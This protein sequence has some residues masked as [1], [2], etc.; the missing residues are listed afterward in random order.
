MNRSHLGACAV[1]ALL[2]A[3]PASAMG[4]GPQI[5]YVPNSL[6]ELKINLGPWT[7]HEEGEYF[8]HD[9][10]GIVPTGSRPPYTGSGR[11]YAGYCDARGTL[12]RN[13]GFS[14]S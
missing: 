1:V 14:S 10:S 11:P 9:A 12:E 6:V 8:H 7:L 3:A 2:A 5:S 13:Q 4:S